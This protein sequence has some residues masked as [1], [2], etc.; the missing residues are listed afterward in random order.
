MTSFVNMSVVIS[1][2]FAS[3][4]RG[5]YNLTSCLVKSLDYS[6]SLHPFARSARN[7]WASTFGSKT[8]APFRS[9][10]S[11]GVK[12]NWVGFPKASQTAWILVLN[13]ATLRPMHSFFSDFLLHRYCVDERE[14]SLEGRLQPFEIAPRWQGSPEPA[15]A[16]SNVEVP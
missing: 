5:N 11:R 15:V 2:F 4:F 9:W 8:S 10:A 1:R 12:E 3:R 6:L 13:P 16:F 7:A 14:R